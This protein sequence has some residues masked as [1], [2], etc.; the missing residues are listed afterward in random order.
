M[1][2]GPGS[3]VTRPPPTWS[4]CRSA[5]TSWSPCRNTPRGATAPPAPSASGCG[6]WCRTCCRARTG[7]GG[8]VMSRRPETAR[9][10]T[11]GT[12][13]RATARRASRA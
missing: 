12:G 6:A 3:C 1:R 13:A 5:G 11:A 7:N 8:Q 4:P 9:K 10:T 2:S